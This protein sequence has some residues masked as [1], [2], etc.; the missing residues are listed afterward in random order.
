[1][2]VAEWSDLFPLVEVQ[3]LAYTPEID[4]WSSATWTPSG[5]T[6]MVLPVKLTSSER[7]VRG[8]TDTKIACQFYADLPLTLTEADRLRHPT[9][10]DFTISSVVRYTSTGMARIDAE[11]TR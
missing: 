6:I 10:G 8:K 4:E 3:P 9:E 1:M 5:P 2:S 7:Y 11:L